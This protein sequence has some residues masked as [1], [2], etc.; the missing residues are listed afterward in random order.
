MALKVLSTS[1]GLDGPKP[2]AQLVNNTDQCRK[3]KREKEVNR[4]SCDY[5]KVVVFTLM[6]YLLTHNWSEYDSE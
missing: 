6:T 2:W 4:T 5:K 1:N 3:K